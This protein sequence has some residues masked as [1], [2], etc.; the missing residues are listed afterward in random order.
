[1]LSVLVSSLNLTRGGCFSYFDTY[2][3]Y[4]FSAIVCG[5]LFHIA[6]AWF[7]GLEEIVFACQQ[8]GLPEPGVYFQIC[9]KYLSLVIF[10]AAFVLALNQNSHDIIVD[11]M[12]VDITWTLKLVGYSLSTV[13]LLAVLICAIKA[14]SKQQG[15]NF[16][17]KFLLSISPTED[18]P[19]IIESGTGARAHA[20]HYFYLYASTAINK[21]RLFYGMRTR[22]NQVEPFDDSVS[23]RSYGSGPSHWSEGS[24]GGEHPAEEVPRPEVRPDEARPEGAPSEEAHP[25]A[26]FSDTTDVNHEQ[27][28][29]VRFSVSERDIRKTLRKSRR[30][31]ADNEIVKRGA[32]AIL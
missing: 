17:E 22:I 1:L 25:H 7:W 28:G 29:H 15:K 24:H 31:A 23:V 16:K 19:D 8:M 18:H 30:F 9:W 21:C 12:K 2:I 27:G 5:L 14:I 20:S 32:C 13:P 3:T 4:S 6:M 10:T 26:H 11:R